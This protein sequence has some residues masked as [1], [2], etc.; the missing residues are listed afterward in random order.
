M[1]LTGHLADGDLGRWCAANLTG[2]PRLAA[3]VAAAA[4]TTPPARPARIDD[5]R[6]WA[7]IGGAL[8]QRLAFAVQHA[9]PYYALLG[10]HRA[11]L[12]DRATVH[13]CAVRFPTHTGLTTSER[14]RANQLRPLPDGHW[15]DLDPPDP[16]PRADDTSA[17][18]E[19]VAEFIDRL[20]AFLAAH[21]APGRLA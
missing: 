8:G 14:A 1:S 5:A 18:H 11:G 17:R 13:A 2:T 4:A 20:A 10:A 16:P 7:T 3:E 21:A 6:H 9:P 19:L 15:R 12:A